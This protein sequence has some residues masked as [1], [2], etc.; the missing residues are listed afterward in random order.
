[1]AQHERSFQAWFDEVRDYTLRLVGIRSVSPSAGESEVA[2]EVVRLLCQGGLGAAYTAVGLDPLA[3]DAYGRHTAYAFL[4]GASARTIVL[5]GHIDTVDTADFGAQEPWALD[6]L[7]LSGRLDALVQRAP[8]AAHDLAT[9]PDDWLFGRGVIDM[10]SGVAAN[11]AVMRHLA[12]LASAGTL[13][14]SVVFLATPDEENESAG[15]L[16]SVRFLL[17][18]RDEHGLTYLGAINTDYTTAQYPGDPHHYIYTGTIGKLLPSVLAVGRESHVGDPFDGLDANLLV[19]E[20]IRDLSMNDALCDVVRGQAVPPPVT[21]H[22]ADLKSTYDVQLPFAASFYLNVLTLSMTPGA[23]LERLREVA[24]SALT[25]LLRRLDETE[26][27]WLAAAG[28]AARAASVSPRRGAVLTYAE[29]HAA[30]VKR[31]GAA[32]VAGALNEE[33]SR[34]PEQL[35]KR[36]RSMQLVWRLWQVAG[37]AGPAVVLYY[38]PPYYPHVAA[39]PCPLH[40]AVAAVAAAHPEL[41]LRVEEFFPYLSDLSY[42]RLHNETDIAPLTA[43]MPVWRDPAAPARP[44]SYTLPLEAIRALDMPVVNLGPY[45]AGAHQASERARMSYSFGTLPQLL[46]ETIQRLG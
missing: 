26:A 10:K 31:V 4:K 6:P 16:Q 25:R 15:V 21:L 42:L 3:G 27:R 40:D 1:M 5:L 34:W 19:A 12:G 23:L 17:R 2:R 24:Q 11:I 41:S 20:L 45:G 36:T 13:P 30:A 7:A 33:W 39:S 18:R 44:G 37:A 43:N 28:K 22:A 38:S 46:L 9:H 14:L 35:D 32:A 29:L 8:A